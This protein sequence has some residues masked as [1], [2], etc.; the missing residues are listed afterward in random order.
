MSIILF[1]CL[2]YLT[3]AQPPDSNPEG[4]PDL[5]IDGGVGV[6]IAA[7]I[8]YGFKKMRDN[9]KKKDSILQK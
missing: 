1:S 6:L 3:F 7:G 4:D 5:P 2:P 9:R 8:G